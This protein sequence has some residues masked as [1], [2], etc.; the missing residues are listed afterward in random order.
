MELIVICI[1][2]SVISY[3]P[4]IF[5]KF[6][7]IAALVVFLFAPPAVY[8]ETT[9]QIRLDQIITSGVL[10][11]GTTG[12]YRPFTFR[13]PKTGN[14]AGFDIDQAHDLG[15]ALGVR[16]EFVPTSW[17]TMAKDFEN[18]KFDIA[19][20]GV[21]I[22]RERQKKGLFSLPYLQDGKTP[23]ARCS[24]HN[25]YTTIADI[26]QPSVRVI[27]NPGGTNESFV[28]ANIKQAQIEIWNDNTTIFDE[29]AAGKADVM[30][31]DASETRYQQRIHA[32]VLCAV[33][34]DK[35]FNSVEKAY[36][37]QRAPF[38]A[39]FVDQWLRQAKRNGTFD[40]IYEKWF[41]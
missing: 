26:D 2:L 17:P 3:F 41:M 14:F 22:T 23:I 24:D 27:V 19:M 40:A 33:H 36:W 11:V 21:S 18:N 9:P 4:G 38:F 1:F 31:T 25:L 8:A 32:G 7:N 15:R 16:V 20:G 34:P 28:H 39:A 13:D 10:K 37:I 35:P 6:F 5:M 30:I 29:L 12:D